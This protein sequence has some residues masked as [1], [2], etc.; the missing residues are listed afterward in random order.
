LTLATADGDTRAHVERYVCKQFP[1]VVAHA[2]PEGVGAGRL[3]FLISANPEPISDQKPVM[4]FF[5]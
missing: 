2:L 3:V 4:G 5:I 1:L